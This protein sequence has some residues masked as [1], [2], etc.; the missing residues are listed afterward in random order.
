MHFE[1]LG[2]E[3][4]KRDEMEMKVFA[5]LGLDRIKRGE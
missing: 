3:G 4:R 2:M 5:G 1:E